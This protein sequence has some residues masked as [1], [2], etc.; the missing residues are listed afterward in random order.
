MILS[1]PTEQAETSAI[2]PKKQRLLIGKDASQMYEFYGIN[3]MLSTKE[4]GEISWWSEVQSKKT[5]R[6]NHD[7]FVTSV[8]LYHSKETLHTVLIES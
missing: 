3:P 4:M 5:A 8:L 2:V 6:Q 7:I 1:F